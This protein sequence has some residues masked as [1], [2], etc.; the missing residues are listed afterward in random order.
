MSSGPPQLIETT[1][2][3]WVVSLTAV[4]TASMNPASVLGAKYTTID[5]AGAIAPIISMSS[6]TSPSALVSIPGEFAPPSTL[7]AVTF[8]GASPSPWKYALRSSV[9]NPPPSSTIPTV[10]PSPVA[11]AG[12]L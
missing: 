8:G 7:T 2:G 6:I 3:R 1:D 4:E 5:A 10:S 9:S 11:C 12:K